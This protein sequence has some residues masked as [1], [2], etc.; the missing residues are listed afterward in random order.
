MAI[1]DM[2]EMRNKMH[3]FKDREDAGKILARFLGEKL[4]NKENLVVLA[5]PRGGIPIGCIVAQELNAEFDLVIVRKIPIPGDPEAGFGAITPDGKIF[6][7]KRIVQYIGL[8]RKLIDE[9]AKEVLKEIKRRE[10]V[11][12]KGKERVDLRDK[13][14]IL[15]DDGLATGYTMLAAIEYVKKRNPK[16][17]FVATPT[18]SEG[19]IFRLSRR[20][21]TIFCLNIRTEIPYFA[22]A[23]A[24][25]Y[26]KDLTDNDVITILKKYGYVE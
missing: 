21:D 25:I 12:L 10:E 9:L 14:V 5:I 18:A 13:N 16:K 24:Y 26:W 2:P 23:D 3:V 8:N 15:V 4:D 19:A 17:I 22:V 11:L 6:F 1:I 7:D 20:V